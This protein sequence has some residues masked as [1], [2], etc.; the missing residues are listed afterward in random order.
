MSPAAV[1]VTVRLTEREM[2]ALFWSVI[3]RWDLDVHPEQLLHDFDGFE[4]G[5]AGELGGSG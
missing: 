4:S 3:I 5:D 1:T 2:I